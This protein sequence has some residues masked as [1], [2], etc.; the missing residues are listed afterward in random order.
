LAVSVGIDK[1]TAIRL[2]RTLTICGYVRQDPQR[3]YSLT[4]KL[5][6]L[7]HRSLDETPLGEVARPFLIALRD[8]TAET[9]HLGILEHERVVYIQKLDSPQTIQLFSRLGDSM[10]IT[11][12]ALGKA[13][14][15][16]LSY[17]R[18]DE[19][20]ANLAFEARTVR[21]ITTA[22]RL[23]EEIAATRA[24]GYAVDDRENEEGIVCVG[25]AI[26]DAHHV[27]TEPAAVSISGPDFRILP[28]VSQLGPLCQQSAN[29]ISKALG[30]SDADHR[31]AH[32]ARGDGQREPSP[33]ESR[34]PAHV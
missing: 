1:A 11:T 2:L 23:R 9:V 30:L 26:S 24:R 16:S 17:D 29:R 13:I 19:L 3:R 5:L 22:E 27:L 21:S 25:A 20:L 18:L 7:A 14:C 28:R 15:A 10:P 33:R 34:R 4:A 6:R 32:D 12:T 31:Y 8:E